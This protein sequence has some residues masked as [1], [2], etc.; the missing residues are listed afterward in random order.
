[1]V[2]VLSPTLDL[3]AVLR[4]A[5][6]AEPDT[7][8]AWL[9][10]P[11]PTMQQLY[12]SAALDDGVD[13]AAVA[14]DLTAWRLHERAGLQVL[15]D[16]PAAPGVTVAL[17]WRLGPVWLSMACRV[18]ATVDT[19]ERRGFSY[20]TLPGHPERGVESFAVVTDDRG[21]RFELLAVSEHVH[22]AARV[23]PPIARWLQR[24]ATAAYR[25]A[26]QDRTPGPGDGPALAPR[27]PRRDPPPT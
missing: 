21:S 17:G 22:P 26:A 7:D 1:M 10:D 5:R 25:R 23:A 12:E 4:R 14:A 8:G 6:T 27:T 11:P 15:A 18:I 24:R 9:D 3:A 2:G 19:P 20:A 13:P 16:G